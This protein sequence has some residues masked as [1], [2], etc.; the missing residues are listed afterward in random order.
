M[1]VSEELDMAH[2]MK[3]DLQML[4]RLEKTI[5]MMMDSLYL[6]EIIKKITF[7]TER[8]LMIYVYIMTDLFQP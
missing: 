4:I 6:L 3:Y 8:R 2:V 7:T 1:K 5:F